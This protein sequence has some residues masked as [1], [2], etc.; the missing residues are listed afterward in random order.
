LRCCRSGLVRAAMGGRARS[1]CGRAR[2]GWDGPG[3]SGAVQDRG[4]HGNPSPARRRQDSTVRCTGAYGVVCASPI[5]LTKRQCAIRDQQKPLGF[6]SYEPAAFDR[7]RHGP[8]AFR[9]TAPRR[10]CHHGFARSRRSVGYCRLRLRR[11]AGQDP[12]SFRSLAWCFRI[13]IGR[14]GRSPGYSTGA[15]GGASAGPR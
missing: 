10:T 7:H 5:S 3:S 11:T 9:G 8:R 13:A 2:R 1:I 4:G 12:E 14:F 15:Q 6:R